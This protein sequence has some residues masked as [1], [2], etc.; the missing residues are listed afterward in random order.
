MDEIYK[1]SSTER[2][3]QLEKELAS[4]LAE[5]KTEIE[6]NGVLQG[7]LDCSV[8]LP[9]DIDYFRR[10]REL[11]LKKCLQVA[12]AKPLVI[13]ADVL[14]RETECCLKREHTPENLPLLLHQFFTDRITQLVQSKYLYMLR[15]K[16]FCQHSS[17][18]EQLYPF[19]QKQVAHIM[20]EYSDAVQR[21]QR[22]SSAREN[23]LTGKENPTNLVTQED[24]TIY[25]QWLICHLHSLKAVH[26][27][28]RALQYLPV[29]HRTEV[30]VDRQQSWN[31][32]DAF[33]TFNKTE[34][35]SS[36][37]QL[38]VRPCTSVPHGHS[39]KEAAS[40]LP[41]HNAEIEDLKPQLRLLLSQFGISY[42]VEDLRHSASEMELLSMVLQKF[43]SI[44]SE[45][46]TM[47]TF[48]VYDA[49][50]P[51]LESWGMNPKMALKKRANWIPFKKIKA[52]QDP[53][54]QKLL[55]KLKQWKKVDEMLLIQSNLLKVSNLEWV[56]ETLQEQ[57]AAVLQPKQSTS[58]FM[59]FNSHQY[60]QI[61][62]NVYHNP[63]FHQ[64]LQANGDDEN[65][66]TATND[67]GM[68]NS[69]LKKGSRFSGKKKDTSYTTTLRLLGLDEDVEASAK[70]LVSRKGAYLSLL[71]LQHLRIRELQ[72]IC[73]GILNYFRSI[74][75]TLTINTSGLALNAGHLASTAEDSCWVNAAK[76]GI[77][78]FGGL[79]SHS[80]VHYTPADYKVHSV[81][82]MEFAEVENHDDFY[83][84][85]DLYIHTQDQRGAF[86]IYDV[87]LQDLKELEE[88]LLL[89]ATQYI[90]RERGQKSSSNSNKNSGWPH[91]S[92]DRFAVLLDLWTCETGFLENK[93]QLL[94]SYFEA[95]QHAL[96]LEERF[97]LAQAI[98]DVMSRRSRIDFHLGYFVNL[99]K[100]ECACLRLHTQLVRDILNQQIDTQRDYNHKIWRDGPKGGIQEF[101]FPP[102]VVPKQLIAVNNSHTALKHIYLL[103]FHPSLGLIS[104]I[105]KALGHIFQ[106]FQ[107]ICR[108]KTAQEAI[109]LDKQVLHLA[110]DTW[111]T[112][113]SPGSFYG[114]QT[115]KELFSGVLVE[116]PSL[117]REIAVSALKSVAKEEQNKGNKEK[118][119][120]ILNIFSRLLELLVL[121]HRLA[122]AAM[123][124]AQMGRL[125]KEFAGEM[126]FDEFHLYL[127]PV[128]FEFATHNEKT[129]QL[130]A[131]FITSL[132]H[133]DSSVDRYIPSTLMLSIQ[134]IDNQIGKFSFRTRESIF[135]ILLNPCGM[136]NL[137]IALACQ[138]THKNLL[139]VAI[140]Q[141]A[142]CPMVQPT[143]SMG[144]KEG[145]LSLRSQSSSATGKNST[146][147]N[148]LEDQLLATTPLSSYF[149]RHIIAGHYNLRRNHEAFVS[150]Q[151]EKQGPRDVMLNAFIQK[152]H[153]LG[154]RMQNTDEAEKVKREV[155]VE[156]CHKLNHRI[157][158][159]SL[160]SQI[161]AYYNSIR[162]MLNDFPSVRAKYF[163]IG[164]P[165]E[166][167]GEAEL[168]G[169]LGD[170]PRSFQPRPRCLL[171]SDGR[172][173]L[174]LWFI[175]HPSEVLS[176]FRMLPQKTG[177]RA[178]K[179]TL[180]LVAAFHDIISYI[181]S[182]V[183]LGS[184]P[185]CFDYF[186][187]SDHL[188][189]DWGGTGWIGNELQELQKKIDY[190]H[191]PTDPKKV[192]QMLS[193]HRELLLLQ[194]DAAVRHS[195]R[196]AFLSSGN[197]CA[198]QNIT[199]NIYHGLPLLS[200]AV[201][202]SLFASQF[203]L[204]QP[205]DPHGRRAD[206]LFP[207]RT[208]QANSSSFPVVI[209]NLNPIDYCMQLCLCGL[210]YEERKTAH[211][212]LVGMQFIIEDVLLN[213]YETPSDL[214]SQQ[215]SFKKLDLATIAEASGKPSEAPLELLNSMASCAPQ[216]SYLILWKQ[217]ETLKA[218]WGRLKLK[219]EDINTIALYKQFSELYSVEV[220]CP[221][222][223]RRGI[224][225]EFEGF[226]ATSQ[227]VYPLKEASQVEIK[228][229]QLQKLLESLEV[230][231]IHDVQKKV[232]KEITLVISEKARHERNLPTELWK[233]H[234]MQEIF[235]VTRPEIVESFIQRLMEN[236]QESEAEISFQKDH[237][238]KC[239]TALGCDVMARERS[240]FENYSMFYEN[241]LHR[242]HQLLYK[243]EQE[244]ATTE[245]KG[246]NA[247]LNLSQVAE[248]NHDMIMEITALRAKTADLQEENHSLRE[249][250]RKEVQEDYE[251]L[252]QSMFMTCVHLKGKVDEYR[253]S[254]SQR[255]FEII[256]EVRRDGVDKMIALKKKFGSTK[257][258][259][260]LKERLAQEQ[261]QELRDENGQL[262]MLVLKL[263]AM[264]YWKQTVHKAHLSATVREAEKVDNKNK[265]EYLKLKMMAEKEAV[266]FRQQLRSARKALAQSQAEN[267]KLNGQL[268]K[269]GHLLQ[270]VEQKMNQEVSRWQQVNLMKTENLEKMLENLAE[271]EVK[272]Q[273]LTEEAE[274][275]TKIQQLQ[276][277]RV[278][279]E[280]QQIRSQLTQERS[281]KLNAYQR[282]EELQSQLY[283]VEATTSQRNSPGATRRKSANLLRSNSSICHNFSGTASW[284]Q[285][286]RLSPFMLT[287]DIRH[288]LLTADP[289]GRSKSE[290]IPRPKTVP[291][292]GRNSV[293]DALL[294][295]L[296]ED[297]SKIKY[298]CE[299][300]PDI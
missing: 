221:A 160:R 220:L 219:V 154:S 4:Q 22:L 196:E 225:V 249:K 27:Y 62:E 18:V 118:Q 32:E 85:E 146:A 297:I 235:S 201:V 61:W 71:Y 53:W 265:K 290:K 69:C 212:E 171:S 285:Q 156:Y 167:K 241:I 86:V 52:K 44:F 231:M 26:N 60:D 251:A 198:Y 185:D 237:L 125:Y 147:G 101:G 111:L 258:N 206:M 38:F 3:Q 222:M 268:D 218:E 183:Q 177:Y 286:T 124:S 282:V 213:N 272:L 173:F 178:L 127:R 24:L 170:D 91:G 245:D 299:S 25:T 250:I 76:G 202:G 256:S 186:C 263:R 55:M 182:F 257:D 255:M 203:Q 278:K 262:Q 226:G 87:A 93:R 129:D 40:A 266:L 136:E 12:E 100:D 50:N 176:L 7:S 58:A 77:G 193:M 292:G 149:T 5:L 271:K 189:A 79:D 36:N 238:Q 228:T 135:Q 288:N 275:S 106:E 59:T 197:I 19:Y 74:E 207:W 247:E 188:S 21:A 253:L 248:M 215:T 90:E 46:Q 172:S 229:Y 35:L 121:R 99:Y 120:L 123:E 164:L 295:D 48:P 28:L 259:S 138:I 298:G 126:G 234:S 23:F 232:N 148:E 261:L 205:L 240:N 13:Q 30:S 254:L 57:A 143:R 192:A 244:M 211:G 168:K 284:C 34:F 157:S 151:L 11:A 41:Q 108:P 42:D 2:V 141:A 128:Y 54:Q 68:E 72:R 82:F 277:K 139:L 270:K 227:S 51:G 56:M 174:N 175:P 109:Q 67:Q 152:K 47:R 217:L 64:E 31:E 165:H 280:I 39:S 15:W 287:R 134:D 130:A 16:R 73:L 137:Q 33:K 230:H 140:Q 37:I 102:Y 289:V 293:I 242:Q 97:T 273:S 162:A 29:S 110:L 122:E 300:G 83:T 78:A 43:R 14:Q 187:S 132:E 98:T 159:Y 191:N 216:K 8:R 181:F 169:K 208:F 155:I 150:I 223:R 115:Q 131:T 65:P 252:V 119:M 80:Y 296:R 66:A 279:K 283:D 291:S 75:R 114:S 105:P 158:Q 200:N 145:A 269:Q 276:G 180:Q 274:K 133:Q 209:D 163:I 10:E 236:H 195:M 63:E 95:Y 239:L 214:S 81:Q 243:K 45:Q 117:V 9:K 116:D 70:D 112:L 84:V 113:E 210:N 153:I 96:V 233:H 260:A 194:F 190:L 199:D 17:V 89:V 224:E 103:E 179:Q 144:I 49:A 204:P 246:V 281:L 107:Q 1:I 104:L 142:F 267:K 94:D 6:G 294:P 88:Q 264:N 184:P 166:K 20:Q 92:V 161:I